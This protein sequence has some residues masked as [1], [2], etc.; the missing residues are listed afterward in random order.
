MSYNNYNRNIP[1]RSGYLA[2]NRLVETTC[3]ML[4]SDNPAKWIA[5]IA[6]GTIAVGA[7]AISAISRMEER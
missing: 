5:G 4:T 2:K 7:L 6:V 3:D 1:M